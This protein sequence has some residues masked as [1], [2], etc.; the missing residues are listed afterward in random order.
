MRKQRVYVLTLKTWWEY[1][2]AHH[3][4]GRIHWYDDDD[5]GVA[6]SKSLP[7]RDGFCTIRHKTR[8][9]AISGARRWYVARND[10]GSVLV[11][12]VWGLAGWARD[13]PFEVLEGV[14]APDVPDA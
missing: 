14:F 3:T 9:E 6:D 12:G 8:E 2:R 4:Y 7:D 10:V 1:D 11:L 13:E 5:F